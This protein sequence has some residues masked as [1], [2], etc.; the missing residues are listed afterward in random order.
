M[1]ENPTVFALLGPTASGK[2]NLALALADQL[3]CEIISLD[4]VMVYKGLDIGSAKPSADELA[5]VPHHLIDICDVQTQYSV[6]QFIADAKQAIDQVLSRGK[7][8]LLVGGTMMYY[9]ALTQGLS[10]SLPATD[11]DVRAAL[12]AQ[13]QSQG[14]E[15][16]HQRLADIDP[17]TAARLALLDKQRI[18]RALEVYEMTGQPMSAFHQG[19]A[20]DNAGYQWCPIAIMPEDRSVLRARIGL[21][22]NQMLAQGLIEEVM[23]FYQQGVQYAGL[24]S[25]GYA[26]VWDYLAGRLHYQQ[27]RQTIIESTA[28]L[29]KRQLTWLRSLPD[30]SLIPMEEKDQSKLILRIINANY[31]I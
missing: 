29:A 11:Q 23:P 15:S 22:A 27:M 17:M 31:A 28:Q 19:E 12:E 30:L 26:Q 9:R 2:T 5:T 8:P 1:K 14:L 18:L 21:R 24:K 10:A 3:P 20:D 16:M 25:I 13:A 7:L 6:G 4:S